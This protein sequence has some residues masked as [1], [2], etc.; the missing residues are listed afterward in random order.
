MTT[1]TIRFAP[2]IL[3]RLGEE[4][5]PHPDQGLIELVRNSY[6]ADAIKCTIEIHPEG[7]GLI[8]IDDDGDGMDAA[9]LRQGFLVVGRSQKSASTYTRLHRRQVGDKGLGR[10]AALRLGRLVRIATRP[11]NEP[12]A[13]YQ[14]SID[15]RK[16]DDADVV[17]SVPIEVKRVRTDSKHGTSIEIRDWKTRMGRPQIRRLARGLVLLADPFVETPHAFRPR[18]VAPEFAD[19]E[20]RVKEAYFSAA[21]YHLEARVDDAGRP[22]AFVSDAHGKRLFTARGAA[23]RAEPYRTPP[24]KFD[25]WTYLLGSSF[26][27]RGASRDEVRGWL[28]VV[29]GVHVY[30]RGLRVYPYGEPGHDWLDMNLGRVRS[31]EERPSTNNSIGKVIVDDP[32]GLLLQK[33]DRSGFVENEEFQEL[34]QFCVDALD[35]MANERLKAAERRRA[36]ERRRLPQETERAKK[37]VEEIIAT[38][39]P[40]KRPELAQAYTR[41]ESAQRRE[42]DRLRQ[43]LLLYRTLGTVG[44]TIAL[45]AHEAPRSLD[46]ILG[47]AKAV[48]ERAQKLVSPSDLGRLEKPLGV[49]SE[50]ARSLQSF[51]QL[52][53]RLLDQSRRRVGILEVN[54]CVRETIEVFSDLAKATNVDIVCELVDEDPRIHGTKAAL[55]SVV[56]NLISNSI[57]AFIADTSPRT[58]GRRVQ[59][60][61]GLSDSQVTIRVSDNGPG[62]RGIDLDDIWLPG[63]TTT[64]RGTGLGLTIVRDTV[65]DLGGTV[66]AA[67]HGS[68]GGAEFLVQLPRRQ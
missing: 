14:L 30:Y 8:Q 12:G 40:S 37:R 60:E 61:T 38:L 2:D 42:A 3:S 63:R 9:A 21:N 5:V 15:W 39:P 65:S 23:M 52:P 25:L 11:R 6:D 7:G 58:K 55:D 53:R 56:A 16:F 34:R 4:L 67:G 62:I 57:N 59:V 10:L 31:P 13:E 35:W 46:Q 19:L 50:S 22:T 66:T 33:T 48:L 17:E 49:I 20:S 68:L 29:G 28:E 45:F 32:T 27:S 47:M 43:D 36:E 18:L 51:A 41:L 54:G 1:E 26:V 64:V 24:A 44:T